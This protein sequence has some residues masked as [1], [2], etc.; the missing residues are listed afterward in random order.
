MKSELLHFAIFT[1]GRGGWPLTNVSVY[2]ASGLALEGHTVDIVTLRTS[3]ADLSKFYQQIDGFVLVN[4]YSLGVR[5]TKGSVLSLVKY[6]W[7]RAP[8]VM[9]SQLTY[10]NV[11]A[12][13]AK[14]L[15][16]T[17]TINILLEGTI[18]SKVGAVDS[19]RDTKLWLV[20]WLARLF[21]PYAEGLIAKSYD[22][23][24]DLERLLGKRLAALKTA[25]LPNPYDIGRFPLLAREPVEHI[26]LS[27]NTVP[28]VITVGRLWEQKGFD[29]LIKAFAGVVNERPCR[30]IILGEGPERPRLEALVKDLRLDDVVSLPGW[31]DNPWKYMACATFFVLPSR[32]EGWPSALMEAMA[33]GLPVITTDCPGGGK[34]MVEHGRSGFVVPEEDV[35]ALK[36]AMIKLAMNPELRAQ[37]AVQAVQRAQHYDYK[38]VTK[39]YISFAK[40]L[41]TASKKITQK[42]PV[43]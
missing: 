29:V 39:E 17:R 26:W 19:K 9:F 27:D 6:Y 11:F 22:V 35:E 28:V 13:L 14:Y 33:C 30:L 1:D 15:S 24:S 20:P 38:T 23:L 42:T 36:S 43:R 32:W 4:V 31:V 34:E 25:V 37:L 2:L 10:T 18:L 40:S 7:T 16:L 12:V 5:H 3:K 21:Y 41:L 8:D